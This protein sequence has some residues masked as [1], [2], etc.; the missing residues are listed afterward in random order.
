VADEG[1]PCLQCTN[2]KM[3]IFKGVV[4]FLKKVLCLWVD[5]G[6]FCDII[7]DFSTARVKAVACA[8]YLI[9]EK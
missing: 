4:F 5:A 2:L 1:L 7:K 6:A 3:V 8:V 9:D